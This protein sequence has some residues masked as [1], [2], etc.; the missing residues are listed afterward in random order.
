MV[1]Q[2]ASNVIFAKGSGN[3]LP[4]ILGKSNTTVIFVDT[5]AAEQIACV[6][7][8]S[9]QYFRAMVNEELNK[10]IP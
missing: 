4:F 8:R 10:N 1:L 3:L 6:F 9:T 5:H 7:I 2:D